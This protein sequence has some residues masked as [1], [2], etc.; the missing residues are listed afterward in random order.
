MNH[1]GTDWSSKVCTNLPLSPCSLLFTISVVGIYIVLRHCHLSRLKLW[2]LV[3]RDADCL[4]IWRRCWTSCWLWLQLVHSR[5]LHQIL[6]PTCSSQPTRF[7]ALCSLYIAVVMSVRLWL[8]TAITV[9]LKMMYFKDFCHSVLCK[10]GLCR[11]AVSV[12]L[13]VCLSRLCIVSK[14]INVFSKF[15]HHWVAKPF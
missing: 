1:R 11:H 14:W 4:C 13:C 2:L 3:P 10:H 15:F 8:V 6:G 9:G 5:N 12:C 7:T